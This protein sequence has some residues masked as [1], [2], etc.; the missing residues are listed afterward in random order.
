MRHTGLIAAVLA[1]GVIS[2]GC[3]ILPAHDNPARGAMLGAGA[4]AVI[5][6]QYGNGGRDKGALIGGVLG[7]TAGLFYDQK[8]REIQ[9]QY[10]D[11]NYPPRVRREAAPD[12]SGMRRHGGYY[13]QYPEEEYYYAP[14]R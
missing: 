2:M 11:T 8:E 4:G 3:A 12:N 14:R 13:Y 10:R 1:T 5:G 6:H 9:N 7:Y